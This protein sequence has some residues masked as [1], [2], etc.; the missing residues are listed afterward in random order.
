MKIYSFVVNDDNGFSPNPFWD[1]CTIAVGQE[2]IRHLAKVGDWIVG[3]KEKSS[4][5]EDHSLL[6][7]MQITE[8]LTFKEYWEN[9]RFQVKKPDFTLDEQIY[10]VGDNFYEPDKKGFKQHYSLHSRDYF[11]SDE[12]WEEQKREDIQGEYVLISEKKYFHYFGKKPEPLPSTELID[13][14]YCDIGHKCIADPEAPK[15]FLDFIK[16]LKKEKKFG[17]INPPENWPSKDDSW[18]QCEP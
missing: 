12:N 3:L 10:H 11:D 17:F 4:K 6:F 14:L 8:K 13:V 18:K 1:Y 7:A 2:L 5:L 15:D 16:K 9:P